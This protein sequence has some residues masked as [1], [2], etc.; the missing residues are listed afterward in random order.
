MSKISEI[1]E[2]LTDDIIFVLKKDLKTENNIFKA[3]T[4]VAFEKKYHTMYHDCYN[5]YSSDKSDYMYIHRTQELVNLF[6]NVLE[7]D[8]ERTNQYKSF[9]SET[10]I[11]VSAIIIITLY[12]TGFVALSVFLWKADTS[13]NFIETLFF[14]SVM[15]FVL[16]M[17]CFTDICL[18]VVRLHKKAQMELAD[19][20]SELLQ[21]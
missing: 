15:F 19:K 11:N 18:S 17:S 9:L 5:V 10:H 14:N 13:M 4:R 20:R 16:A 12:V 8:V 7:I 1:L 6:C 21:N 3:G 2:K